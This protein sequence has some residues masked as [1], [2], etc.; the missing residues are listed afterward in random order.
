MKLTPQKLEGWD[1]RMVYHYPNFNRFLY[2]PPMWRMDRQTDRR[3]G[4]SM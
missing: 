1:Y 4:D 2:D 3:T